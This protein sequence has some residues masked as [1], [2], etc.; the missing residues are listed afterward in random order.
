M[1]L[2]IPVFPFINIRISLLPLSPKHH[3]FVLGKHVKYRIY[4]MSNYRTIIHGIFKFR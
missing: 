2:A 3:M 4:L 1:I